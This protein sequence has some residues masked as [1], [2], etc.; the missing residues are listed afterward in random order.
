MYGKIFVTQMQV[1]PFEL[2][3]AGNSKVNSRFSLDC[4]L[5]LDFMILL[6][7]IKFDEDPIKNEGTIYP[8]Q[9]LPHYKVVYGKTF[10]PLRTSNS[11]VNSL[12]WLKFELF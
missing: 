1:T 7:I 6:G 12:I 8:E 2:S 5:I 11:E 10:R 9:H 4:K 3:R